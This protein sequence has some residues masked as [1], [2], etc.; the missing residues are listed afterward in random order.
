[1]Y[2]VTAR[3][4]TFSYKGSAPDVRDAAMALGVNYVLEGSVRTSGG[5]VRI[6]AQLIEVTSGNHV[7]ADRYDR[8]I[9]DD[10]A[11]Q[12]EIAQRVSSILGERIWQ[13]VAKSIGHKSEESFGPYE[14][15]YVGIELLHK[16]E[17]DDVERA[18]EYIQKALELAPDLPPGHL[19]M[20]FC[21]MCDWQFWGD[22]TNTALDKAHQHALKLRDLAPD[23]AQTYRLLSRVFNATG[24]L[25][26]SWKCVERALSINPN[27]GDII[28]NRGVYHLFHG[29]FEAAH[30]WLDKVLALHADTPHTVDIMHFWKS[31][32]YFSQG[33]YETANAS[34]GGLSS[35]NF[36]RNLLSCACYDRLDQPEK[37]RTR[38]EAVLQARPQFKLADQGLWKAFNKEV[39]Q[40]HL[41]GAL[42][43][44]GL[45][46]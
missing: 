34:I 15:V 35:L 43:R 41:F 17:P 8:K 32:T 13:D 9:G 29:E 25:D 45:P 46:E 39:D 7:W 28:A 1:M 38:A 27:D 6:N 31:L 30:E 16:L 23:D 21:C 10:F 14:Y 11:L 18:K 37:A 3:N 36:L 44:A 19:G 33:D 40:R 26:A 22:S 2:D 5:S 4:S 42:S 20:G 12:D 24:E